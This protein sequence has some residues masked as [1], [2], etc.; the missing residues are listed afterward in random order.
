MALRTGIVGAGI[1]SQNNHLPA[2][3][4]N[5]RTELAAVCDRDESAVREQSA[6]TADGPTRT[7][8]RCSR[9]RPSTG[10]T[11]PRRSRATSTSPAR[12]SSAGFR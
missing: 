8:R 9:R 5:P 4:R 7:P 11:S 12:R 10:S 6:S 1:V 2:V 3:S